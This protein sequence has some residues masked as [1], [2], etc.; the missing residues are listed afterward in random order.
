VSPA[1]SAYSLYVF[2]GDGL[3]A[4]GIVGDRQHD[5]RNTLAT[6]FGNQAL[7]RSN[8]HVAFERMVHTGLAP[9]RNDHIQCFGSYKFHIRPRRIEVRVVGNHIALLAHDTEENAFGSA[10][11]VGRDDMPVAEDVLHRVAKAVKATAPGITLVAFHDCGP[12]VRGHGS[13]TRIR[14]EVNQDVVGRQQEEVVV[15]GL[16]KAL[17]LGARR[18]ADRLDTL[19]AKGLDDGAGHENLLYNDDCI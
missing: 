14:E 10:P 12:L 1:N 6:H 9:F 13:G 17:A 19:D 8:V 15:G 3:A 5:E 7:K 18:P 4:S 2:H 11:L 16:E